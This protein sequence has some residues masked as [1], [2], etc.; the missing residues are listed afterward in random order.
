MEDL[1]RQGDGVGRPQARAP[2][3]GLGGRLVPDDAARV[4]AGAD[5][6]DVQ[7]FEDVADRAVLPRRAVQDGEDDVG[8]VVGQGVQECRVGVAEL[9]RDVAG[10][11]RVG[12][13]PAGTEGDLPLVGE[14]PGEDDDMPEFQDDPRFT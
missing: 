2:H 1:L 5:I 12:D 7:E 13:P 8:R 9:D 3:D 4:R 14:P 10:A 6:G 11:Q